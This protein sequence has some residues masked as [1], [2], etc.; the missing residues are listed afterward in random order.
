MIFFYQRLTT[1]SQA[2]S[3]HRYIDMLVHRTITVRYVLIFVQLNLYG[4]CASVVQT[5]IWLC[6]QHQILSF[7]M[8]DPDN[9]QTNG[10]LCQKSIWAL[11]FHGRKSIDTICAIL[12]GS[13]TSCKLYILDLDMYIMKVIY[14]M[15]VSLSKFIYLS[16]LSFMYDII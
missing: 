14:I 7:M 12:C 2:T 5:G 4:V 1:H 10:Q 13:S 15:L 3:L 9:R 8:S 11:I 16:H 6:D